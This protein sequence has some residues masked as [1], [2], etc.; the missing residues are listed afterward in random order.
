M[1][2]LLLWAHAALAFT[3]HADWLFITDLPL[4]VICTG[5]LLCWQPWKTRRVPLLWSLYVAFAWLPVALALSSAQ[6]L[7][8]RFSGVYILGLAPLHAL[9]I[10][11]AA[12]MVFAMVTRVSMGHSGRPLRMPGFAVVCFLI[13]QLAVIARICAELSPTGSGRTTCLMLSVI[14][15]LCAFT[16]WALRLSLIYWQ[17]R[18]DGRPG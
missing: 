15:W 13:L 10:G 9:A 1:V 4:L 8:L 16:P 18:A 5:H 17:P 3:G 2:V 6:S 7:A 12:S 14:F 11:L